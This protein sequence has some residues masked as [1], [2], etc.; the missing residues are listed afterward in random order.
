MEVFADDKTS[1]SCAILK[2]GPRE[3][4]FGRDFECSKVI[5]QKV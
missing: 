4:R 1:V 3:V 2:I 5:V